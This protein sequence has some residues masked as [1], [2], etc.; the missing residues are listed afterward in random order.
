M[1]P[2][3][4]ILHVADRFARFWGVFWIDGRSHDQ[5]R[6]TLSQ[7]VAKLGRVDPN[8]KAALNWLSNQEE[9]WLLIIDNA[10]DPGIELKEYLPKG[11]RGYVLITTR[12][13]GYQ[14]LGNVEPGFFKFHGMKNEDASTLLLRTAGFYPSSDEV[15]AFAT[16]IVETLGYL[17]LAI[18]VAGSAIREGYCR[19]QNYLRY[20]EDM[21]ETRRRSQTRDRAMAL[22]DFDER[23]C[24]SAHT[25]AI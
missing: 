7:N 20:F 23:R 10:D 24:V 25:F 16:K 6:Q 19:F 2:S 13:P 9:R 17:A 1:I 11:G 18:A 5:L 22:D 8:H 4:L 15:T 14:P 21:W 3:I 12:N